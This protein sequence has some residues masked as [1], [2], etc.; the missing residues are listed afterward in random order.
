MISSRIVGTTHQSKRA[1]R[2]VLSTNYTSTGRKVAAASSTRPPSSSLE[3]TVAT[4]ALSAPLRNLSFQRRRWS[5]WTCSFRL[6]LDAL[7]RWRSQRPRYCWSVDS[8]RTVRNSM[9]CSASTLTKSTRLSSLTRL[10]DQASSTVQSSLIRLATCI[11]FWRTTQAHHL[12]ITWFTPS[13]S[14]AEPKSGWET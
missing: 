2:I 1:L 9:L 3:A 4:K 5:R 14:T 8:E 13:W 10:I 6:P 7:S 12:I 11:S